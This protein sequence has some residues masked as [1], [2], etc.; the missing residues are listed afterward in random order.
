MGILA[1]VDSPW[2]PSSWPW[3][4]ILG[5]ACG[6]C[7]CS[8]ASVSRVSGVNLFL[9]QSDVQIGISILT[10]KG[11]QNSV[12]AICSDGWCSGGTASVSG[13]W[14][15]GFGWAVGK[16]LLWMLG[17]V[18]W[19]WLHG[20]CHGR[21]ARIPS[22]ATKLWPGGRADPSLVS[23]ARS[24]SW[25]RDQLLRHVQ[26]SGAG[27]ARG[28]ASVHLWFSRLFVRLRKESLLLKIKI[29]LGADRQ[30]DLS[31]EFF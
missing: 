13:R 31:K 4:Q 14:D 29:L 22:R 16:S 10:L 11:Q 2:L 17:H 23:S 26:Q 8:L 15:G 21:T 6:P 28:F 27:A 9:C 12:V 24:S 20:P 25:A 18:L 19:G 1:S 7:G 30:A 5:G 3:S